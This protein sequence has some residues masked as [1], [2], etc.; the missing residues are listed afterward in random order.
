MYECTEYIS[1]HVPGTGYDYSTLS[2]IILSTLTGT[3]LCT[4]MYYADLY[5]TSLGSE[6]VKY[7]VSLMGLCIRG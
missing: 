1:C 3:I 2:C 5:S 6:I 7:P 4:D